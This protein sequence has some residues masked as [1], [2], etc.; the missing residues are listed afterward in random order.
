MCVIIVAPLCIVGSL[1]TDLMAL[2][3]LLLKDDS[4]FEHKYNSKMNDLT[5][6]QV[7]L[8]TNVF[9]S[10]FYTNNFLRR[11]MNRGLNLLELMTMHLQIFRIS[12]NLHDLWCRGNLDYKT[13][14]ANVE[15]FNQ[16]KTLAR[17]CSIPNQDDI[18]MSVVHMNIVHDVQMD[19][20][21]FNYVDSCMSMYFQGNLRIDTLKRD[22]EA[23]YERS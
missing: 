13:S 14:L 3:G 4:T 19:I 10:T 16:S 22:R 18:R 21:M 6:Q 5:S 1:L 11:F 15:D 12:D 20:E 17:K 8:V 23:I 2:P 7:K 9:L